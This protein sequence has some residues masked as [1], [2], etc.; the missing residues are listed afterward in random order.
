MFYPSS[1]SRF[2]SRVPPCKVLEMGSGIHLPDPSSFFE[3]ESNGLGYI[4]GNK[5]RFPFDTLKQEI[6]GGRSNE[7]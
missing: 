5:G 4:Q 1:D 2:G 3:V 7:N 6:K